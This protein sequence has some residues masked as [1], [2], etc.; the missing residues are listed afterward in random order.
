MNDYGVM[1][2]YLPTLGVVVVEGIAVDVLV[3]AAGVDIRLARHV[4]TLGILLEVGHVVRRVAPLKHRVGRRRLLRTLPKEV[5]AERLGE[6]GRS[7]T[8][9]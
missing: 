1:E 4:N 6:L 5:A 2:Y 8:Y 9:M 7:F 3:P